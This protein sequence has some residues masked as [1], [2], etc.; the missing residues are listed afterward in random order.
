MSEWD[1]LW[2]EKAIDYMGIE[3]RDQSWLKRVKAEGDRLLLD[4]KLLKS[5]HK[6]GELN[7]DLIEASKKLL[8][9][10]ADSFPNADSADYWD[11]DWA[12]K[13]GVYDGSQF[14]SDLF[15]WYD[16]YLRKYETVEKKDWEKLT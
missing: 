8:E 15:E 9:K 7:V 16:L 10:M 11:N 13:T 1:K 5:W 2:Y 6:D 3:I 12:K 4:S 14:N